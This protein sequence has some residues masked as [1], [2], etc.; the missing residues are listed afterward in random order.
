[1]TRPEQAHSRRGSYGTDGRPRRM[2]RSGEWQAI[3]GLER[4]FWRQQG[5]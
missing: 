5:S 2:V 1:M 4:F 3:L